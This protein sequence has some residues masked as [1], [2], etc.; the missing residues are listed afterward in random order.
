MMRPADDAPR[1]L[2]SVF[3]AVAATAYARGWS[4]AT[5]MLALVLAVLLAAA[6]I[7]WLNIRAG[8]LRE[9]NDALARELAEMNVRL[10]CTE[11]QLNRAF[12]TVAERTSFYLRGNGWRDARQQCVKAEAVRIQT[13]LERRGP[14]ERGG[15]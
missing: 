9:Q 6:A 14:T 10:M 2:L 5:G 8:Q 7:G 1:A 11:A 3:D 13:L 12:A 4:K 15:K